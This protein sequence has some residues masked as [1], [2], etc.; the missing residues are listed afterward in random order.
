MLNGNE[1]VLTGGMVTG[2]DDEEMRRLH[3]CVHKLGCSVGLLHGPHGHGFLYYM[4][5]LSDAESTFE[6]SGTSLTPS[7]D[8]TET[9]G[10]RSD[11]G[12]V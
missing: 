11:N 2:G 3:S 4:R 9:A 8:N 12:Y 5:V 1:R 6:I 10:S 7:A